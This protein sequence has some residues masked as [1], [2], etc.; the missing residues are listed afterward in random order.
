MND[1]SARRLLRMATPSQW[2]MGKTFDTFA[3]LGPWIVTRDEIAD[4][5]ALEISLEIGGEL[6]QTFQYP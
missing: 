3:P 1:V 4:P 2:L 5:H 6:L